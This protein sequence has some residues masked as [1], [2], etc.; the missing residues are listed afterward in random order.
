MA[1][2][3]SSAAAVSSIVRPFFHCGVVPACLLQPVMQAEQP[4]VVA[5]RF[6]RLTQW[7]ACGPSGSKAETLV[8]AQQCHVQIRREGLLIHRRHD[9]TAPR[10]ALE[11]WQL[12]G[13][14][15]GDGLVDGRAAEGTG[16]A[17]QR[18]VTAAHRCHRKC[19]AEAGQAVEVRRV[20][21][22]QRAQFQVAA[23]QQ[24]A[25][26]HLHRQAREALLHELRE[27][28]GDARAQV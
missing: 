12:L 13:R 4:E 17:R 9:E 26:E 23:L 15:Q 5:D 11:G 20:E 6:L 2:Q 10:C 28:R 14:V 27:D 16:Q 3:P 7:D 22:C 25:V 24:V 8:D 18:L 19:T 21:L 1:T